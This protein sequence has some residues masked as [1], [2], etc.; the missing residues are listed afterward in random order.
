MVMSLGAPGTLE[1]LVQ[2]HLEAL[3]TSSWPSSHFREHFQPMA[4]DV[5]PERVIAI[6]H[7]VGITCVLMGTHAL[8]TYRDEARATQDVDVLV[9]KKDLAKAIRALRQA[10]PI[11]TIDDTPVV[12]RFVDP[13]SA[14]VVLNV[15]KPTQGVLQ[16]MFRHTLPIGGTHRIPDL[17]MALASKFAAMVSPQRRPDKKMLDGGDFMNVVMHHRQE[18]DIKKLQRLAEKVYPGAV[19][20]VLAMIADIDAGRTLEF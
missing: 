10:Y 6:L 18:I 9:R 3:H 13:A 19:K 1:A 11:L 15:M 17:E 7:E 14:K 12:T 16:V 5:T 20:E 8:N 2:T 4:I